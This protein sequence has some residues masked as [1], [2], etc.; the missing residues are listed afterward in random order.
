MAKKWTGDAE[1]QKRYFQ[2]LEEVNRRWVDTDKA[3]KKI[4]TKGAWQTRTLNTIPADSG[5]IPLGKDN[6]K[7]ERLGKGE[8]KTEWNGSP[9]SGR[10]EFTLPEGY[11]LET[12]DICDHDY[13][14]QQLFTSIIEVC[15]KCD[16]ERQV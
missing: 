14:E 7:I 2:Q 12:S 11:I 8:Y 9:A 4:Y 6:V 13:Q 3:A 16:K 5:L 1:W 15:S 10:Y